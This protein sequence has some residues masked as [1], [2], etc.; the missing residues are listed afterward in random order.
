MFILCGVAA[1][2]EHYNHLFENIRS[3]RKDH[4]VTMP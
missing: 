4:K 3:E 1:Q 2:N